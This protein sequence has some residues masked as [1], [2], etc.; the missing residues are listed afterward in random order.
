M[1]DDHLPK[2]TFYSEITSW[3]SNRGAPRK[4]YKDHLKSSVNACGID[5]QHWLPVAADC[6]RWWSTVCRGVTNF[7]SKRTVNLE[8]A[9][10]LQ[11]GLPVK[12]RTRQA[13]EGLE[14]VWKT[15]FLIFALKPERDDF[16]DKL[17]SCLKGQFKDN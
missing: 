7:E 8:E 11:L 1:K 5:S 16:R 4:R 2:L 3:L 13:A 12:D 17:R 6:E 14:Q 15:P 10:T 9:Q